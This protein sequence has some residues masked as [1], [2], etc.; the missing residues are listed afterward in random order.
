MKNAP[1][2]LSSRGAMNL[3]RLAVWVSDAWAGTR[4]VAGRRSDHSSSGM[5]AASARSM[6][7]FILSSPCMRRDICFPVSSDLRL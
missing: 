1:R 7:A 3:I 6:I 5:S 4:T 2:L